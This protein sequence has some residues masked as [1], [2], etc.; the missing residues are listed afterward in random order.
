MSS[1]RVAIVPPPELPP[2]SEIHAEHLDKLPDLL[3]DL[4]AYVEQGC[5]VRL[6]NFRAHL[7]GVDIAMTDVDQKL[8][9][10]ATPFGGF[11]SAFGVHAKAMAAHDSVNETLKGLA[12]AL[13][14]MVEPTRL[15][16]QNYRNTEE[17]NRASMADIKKL[18]DQG[19]YTPVDPAAISANVATEP[20]A[21]W[22]AP[23]SHGGPSDPHITVSDIV[24]G[25]I[26]LPKKD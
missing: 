18:L 26:R 1:R 3:H 19:Q 17:Q 22:T 15:I 12:Q 9:H 8:H 6:A 7:S 20:T 23:S 25:P 5:I 24:G 21:Q 10:Q 2:N 13:G 11:Y 14:K 4:Q 16:A